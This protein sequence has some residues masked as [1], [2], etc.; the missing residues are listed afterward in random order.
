MPFF[1]AR[2]T[3]ES[4]DTGTRHLP[5]RTWRG[6]A[7]PASRQRSD[8]YRARQAIAGAE[9]R[10]AEVTSRRF[11]CSSSDT[12][13]ARREKLV[14]YLNALPARFSLVGR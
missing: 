5:R 6:V 11:I 10:V 12:L 7:G 1:V 13:L 9:R 3:E 14:I 8:A 2:Q 4:A